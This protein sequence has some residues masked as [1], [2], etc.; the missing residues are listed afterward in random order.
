MR[1]VLRAVLP[2]IFCAGFAAAQTTSTSILGTVSDASGA[3]VSGA[4]VTLTN[5][6]TGQSRS[7]LTTSSGDYNFPLLDIGEYQVTVEMAAYMT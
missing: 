7:M 5:T 1:G 4:K 2:A 3:V 6:G